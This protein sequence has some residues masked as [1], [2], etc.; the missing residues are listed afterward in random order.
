MKD[1]GGA[2]RDGESKFKEDKN[3]RRAS[4]F[5]RDWLDDDM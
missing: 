1:R 4:Y 3:E 2:A 5:A